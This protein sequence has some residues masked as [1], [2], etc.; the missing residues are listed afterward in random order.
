MLRIVAITII[1][2]NIILGIVL[3]QELKYKHIDNSI[4]SQEWTYI[5]AYL[6]KKSIPDCCIVRTDYGFKCI[7]RDKK[8]Y[9]IHTN[10]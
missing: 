10:K 4:S 9:K 6:R 2:L 3:F 5:L 8:V 7:D 1:L